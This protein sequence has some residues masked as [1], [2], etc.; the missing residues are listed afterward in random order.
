MEHKKAA[1]IL[2]KL[3][4]KLPLGAEER[5]AILT[6][7]GVLAWTALSKSRIKALK[8]KRD[9]K[10]GWKKSGGSIIREAKSPQRKKNK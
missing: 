3:L 4:D 5:E 1:D 2:I 8:A 6:A 7:V 10:I 9:K